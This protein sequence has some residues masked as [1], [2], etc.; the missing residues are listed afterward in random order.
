QMCIRDRL[1]RSQ[2]VC[3]SP[4]LNIINGEI[5]SPMS[6][7]KAL[8]SVEIVFHCAAYIGFQKRDF[9]IAYKIN[10]DGT[11]ALL[12]ACLKAGVKKVVHLSA[13]AVLGYSHSPHILIDEDANP[14]IT[15]DNVYAYTKKLA[16][17]IALEYAEKGLDISIANIATVYGSGDTKMNSG[18]VI[19]MVYEGKSRLIPPGGTSFVS[20]SDLVNGLIL[21]AQKGHKGER[22]IFCTENMTY[23]QLFKRISSALGISKAFYPIPRFLRL[24][25]ILAA[26][27]AELVLHKDG[28]NLITEQIIKESFGFKFYNSQKARQ[29]LG[30][31]P[32]Q[33]LEDA[34]IEAFNFYKSKGLI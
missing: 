22:Y 32:K 30:W 25:A 11:K 21:L 20:V 13:C 19:K 4:I 24:P 34:V 17:D 27:C 9:D 3:K 16:E 2:P 5:N 29:S 1:Y 26:K 15:K 7:V 18:S 12:E 28:L 23:A 6:Y 33:T 10:V 8:H 31:T 14:V